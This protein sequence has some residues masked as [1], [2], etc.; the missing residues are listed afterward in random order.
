[1]HLAGNIGGIPHY[2]T[3]T[4]AAFIEESRMKFINADKLHSKSGDMEHP[5]FVGEPGL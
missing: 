3:A 4:F 1:M 2:A 5:S